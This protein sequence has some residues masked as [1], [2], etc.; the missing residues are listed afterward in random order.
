[1]FHDVTIYMKCSNE[2]ENVS[3]RDPSAPAYAPSITGF[4]FN[5]PG[6]YRLKLRVRGKLRRQRFS[7]SEWSSRSL[8]GS[9][10]GAICSAKIW[11]RGLN[12]C[13]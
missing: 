11:L 8:L 3:P 5:I 12:H 13:R 1:M 9:G 7:A 4:D 10:N 6:T 2:V